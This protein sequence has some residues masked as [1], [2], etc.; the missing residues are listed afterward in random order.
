MSRIGKKPI[1]FPTNVFVNVKSKNLIVNGPNGF[2]EQKIPNII[3]V[4]IVKNTLFIK[5][6]IKSKVSKSLHGLVRTLINNMIIG[7]LKKFEIIL[8]LKG[9]GYRCQIKKNILTFNLGYSHPINLEIPTNIMVN[10]TDNNIISIIG[11][12]K[13]HVGLF[14]SQIRTFKPPEPY[15]GK[16]V[17][18][19][20]EKIIRKI[21]KVG[22]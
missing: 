10:I 19:K 14:A 13:E 1:Y 16:G 9:V 15:S 21:G 11:I 7:V 12:N 5:P 6:T 20:N 8:E 22:K 4:E 2:L 3:N 18:Y 17:L